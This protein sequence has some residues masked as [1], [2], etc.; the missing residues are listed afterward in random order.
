[1]AHDVNRTQST[2]SGYN[3]QENL[4]P[5]RKNVVRSDK[6][7]L[8]HP[9][10]PAPSMLTNTLPSAPQVDPMIF[11]MIQQCCNQM[12]QQFTSQFMVPS[13]S[14]FTLNP[15]AT[16]FTPSRVLP[17]SQLPPNDTG[18][19]FKKLN[20]KGALKNLPPNDKEEFD[21]CV[22]KLEHEFADFDDRKIK[23]FSESREW[24]KG[25][26]SIVDIVHSWVV[27]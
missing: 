15:A 13:P 27:Y 7:S 4:N 25:R 26:L 11:N 5:N 23:K 16:P 17:P 21:A 18:D 22:D 20:R 1:M 6:P 3:E 12:F 10:T 14:P 8:P 24:K 9:R 2:Y 19:N